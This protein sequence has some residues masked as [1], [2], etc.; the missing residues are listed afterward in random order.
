MSNFTA[1]SGLALLAL[2]LCSSVSIAQETKS[3]GDEAPIVRLCPA[4]CV[5]VNG[6]GLKAGSKITIYE[7]KSG[8]VRVSEFLNRS[9]LVKSFGNS[10]TSKPALW[11]AE[12]QL[13]GAVKET[14]VAAE[15]AKPAPAATNTN[16][17]SLKRIATPS[18]RPGT[19]FKTTA[20]NADPAQTS[21]SAA[22]TE[23]TDASKPEPKRE[24]TWDELQ[25]KLAE[26]DKQKQT[27]ANAASASGEQSKDVAKAAETAQDTQATAP[28]ATA[29]ATAAAA[30]AVAE[31]QAAEPKR[32]ADAEKVKQTEAAK[33]AEETKQAEAKKLVEEAKKAEEAKV[34]EAARL[35]EETR[36]AE[37][38]KAAEAAKSAEE[39][40]QAEAK[41]LVE[42]AQKAEEA[43][44]AASKEQEPEE[45]TFDMSSAAPIELG[46][47]P[48]TLT[49][50]LLDKRLSKLPGPK[51][52]VRGDVVIAL[53]HYALALL[54]S[55]ECTGIQGGG[56]SAVPGMLY[57][58][59]TDDPGYFRQFPLKEEVW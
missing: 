37:E 5:A 41:K 30:A 12:S 28:A 58:T 17:A 1:R 45:P 38:A 22:N 46:S 19:T 6:H 21:Q 33:L 31:E 34:A 9:A 25:A 36:K 24:M 29:G 54:N 42:E 56:A 14:P 13:E 2:V 50:E 16:L 44:S 59:C 52:K 10:I 15:Q 57:V 7:T 47:R 27:A 49:K 35:A 55:N 8:W 18:F 26:Q 43:K 48:K 51:S 32:M 20:S 4:T 11:V 3:L 53:R 40:K 23:S 39:V